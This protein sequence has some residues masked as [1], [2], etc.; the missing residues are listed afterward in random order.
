MI[1]VDARRLLAAELRANRRRPSAV[2]SPQHRGTVAGA[3]GHRV[4]RRPRYT[5]RSPHGSGGL[6]ADASS[7]AA[8]DLQ[9]AGPEG[10][11]GLCPIRAR[12]HASEGV[13]SAPGVGCYDTV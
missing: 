2:R 12:A 6:E 3:G 5:G 13:R 4:T 8:R 9:P 1:A 10:S 11:P 7:Q